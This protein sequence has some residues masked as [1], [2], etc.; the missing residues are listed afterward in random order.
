DLG[1][2]PGTTPAVFRQLL[3]IYQPNRRTGRHCGQARSAAARAGPPRRAQAADSTRSVAGGL[4][5]IARDDDRRLVKG[6]RVDLI[7]TYPPRSPQSPRLD[8]DPEAAGGSPTG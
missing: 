5:S 8:P 3:S 4:R 7:G 2:R 6:L 1:A